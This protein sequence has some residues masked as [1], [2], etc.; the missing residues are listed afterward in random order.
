M[1][2]ILAPHIDDEMI[3]C[4][5][6]LNEI[7]KVY[8]FF[9]NTKERIK[10]AKAT[11]EKFNF[12]PVFNS[13]INEINFNKDDLVYAPSSFDLHKD[14]RLINRQAKKAQL[15]YKFRLNF[16]S[17]DM[18]R[19]PVL[20]KDALLKKHNLLQLYPSQSTLFNNEKYFLF[21]DIYKKDKTEYQINVINDII[22]Q[23]E[24][25]LNEDIKYAIGTGLI[26]P[27][28]IAVYISDYLPDTELQIQIQNKIHKYNI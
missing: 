2:I 7:D 13:S 6:V 21:E 8:Y 5:S 15:K 17:T 25:N 1:K 11:A 12:E 20:L 24:G 27:D 10:E 23:S 19:K 26:N 16:Y 3:G 14:H 18:N 4:W 22:I 9:E 28:E